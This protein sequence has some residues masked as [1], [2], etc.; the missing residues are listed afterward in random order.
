VVAVESP[1][2]VVDGALN[3]GQIRFFMGDVSV[4]PGDEA[5][6]QM[7]LPAGSIANFR[8]RQIVNTIGPNDAWEFRVRRN[9]IS[10]LAVSGVGPFIG[11]AVDPNFALIADG[12]LIDIVGILTDNGGGPATLV[13]FTASVL[14]QVASFP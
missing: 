8:V 6:V 1:L 10:Q 9:G 7:Q 14:F 12:D 11:E 5:R 13:R 4:A 3:G 2:V